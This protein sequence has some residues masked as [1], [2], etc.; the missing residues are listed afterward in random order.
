MI[1]KVKNF[2]KKTYED[3]IA[4]YAEI[5]ETILLVTGSAVL[6]FTIMDPATKI[7]VPLYLCGSL[8]A[9]ISTYRRGSSAILLVSW[10]TIMNTWAFMQLFIL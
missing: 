7:F 2:F 4:F 8:L 3:K 10:F 1:T 9:L 5:S 6:A